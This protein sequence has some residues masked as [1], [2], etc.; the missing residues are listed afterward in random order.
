MLLQDRTLGRE[1]FLR[2]TDLT[3]QVLDWRLFSSQ[4]AF[5]LG[6][7]INA[8][9]NQYLRLDTIAVGLTEML[10]RELG[11]RAAALRVAAGTVLETWDLWLKLVIAAESDARLY[12]ETPIP[13]DQQQ[14][15]AIGLSD[16]APPMIQAG[17]MADCVARLGTCSQVRGVSI[18]AVLR[19]IRRRAD[20]Y[21]ISLPPFTVDPRDE[22]DFSQWCAEIAAY[23]RAVIARIKTRGKRDKQPGSTDGVRLPPRSTASEVQM[24]LA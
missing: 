14:F 17:L 13:G 10:A 12:Q 5:A 11:G 3:G 4:T 24:A 8:I 23:Q 15:L 2:L 19:G 7:P 9:P 18:Q 22:A 16:G 21:R 1:G 20:T 6:C